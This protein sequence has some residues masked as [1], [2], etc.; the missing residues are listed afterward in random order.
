[1]LFSETS[2]RRFVTPTVWQTVRDRGE[3]QEENITYV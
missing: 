2:Y 1:M 3:G